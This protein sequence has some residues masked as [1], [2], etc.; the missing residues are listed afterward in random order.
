MQIEI[1]DGAY[2]HLSIGHA[3]VPLLPAP[4]LSA[5][6]PGAMAVLKPRRLLTSVAALLVLCGGYEVGRHTGPRGTDL[7]AAQAAPATPSAAA[8]PMREQHAFPDRPLP[9]V[10]AAAAADPSQVPPAFTEQLR[11]APAVQP[12][13]GQPSSGSG[14]VNPFGLHP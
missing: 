11:A 12:P 6:A 2:V 9:R 3:P 5:P 13:P 7:Q 14:G 10:P 1:P 8:A 4:P